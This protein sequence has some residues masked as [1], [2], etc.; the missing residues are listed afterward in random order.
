MRQVSSRWTC[1]HESVADSR[2]G[3]EADFPT[4]ARFRT[5][6]SST[7]VTAAATSRAISSIRTE[8]VASRQ[9][10]DRATALRDSRDSQVEAAEARL[11]LARRDLRRSVLKAPFGGTISVREIDP[12]M[13]VASGQTVFEL[14]SEESGLRVEVQM[15]ETL[16][17]RVRQGDEV[18]VGFPSVGDPGPAAGDRRFAAVISEVVTL[19]VADSTPAALM[20]LVVASTISV[21]ASTTSAVASTI[22][23]VVFR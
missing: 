3:S 12:A 23:S 10:L 20:T 15:P 16:I 21:A 19:A 6:R 9:R 13:K 7:G 17:T 2:S 4:T 8:R 11:E 5:T 14:D 1:R 22:S 18:Q